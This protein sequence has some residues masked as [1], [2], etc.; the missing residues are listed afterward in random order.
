[1]RIFNYKSTLAIVGC[2]FCRSLP[3]GVCEHA[4]FVRF[5]N[6]VQLLVSRAFCRP[7]LPKV[8]PACQSY[9][10]IKCSEHANF[11]D[12]YTKPSS[13][14][15]LMHVLPLLLQKLSRGTLPASS[16]K[17]LPEHASVLRF[18]IRNRPLATVLSTFCRQL[19]Q[20]EPRNCRNRDPPSATAGATLPEKTQGFM[21]ESVCTREF[22]RPRTVTLLYCSHTRT[23]LA[24]F[25]VDMMMLT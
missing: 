12:F 5:L 4:N 25:V 24:H 21:P 15:S 6:A 9:F 10:T 3:K 18:F 13:P 23:A 2:T 17:R 16:S 14:Y 8:P 1:M 19:C 20:I 11:Y 7:P 22:T